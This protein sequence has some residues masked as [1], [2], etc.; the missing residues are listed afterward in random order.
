[1]A[2]RRRINAQGA[3]TEHAFQQRVIGLLRVHGFVHIFHAPAGGHRGRAD[4]EQIPEGR[5]FPDLLAIH[6]LMP[7]ILVVELKATEALAQPGRLRPG[8]AE[9]LAAFQRVGRT[10]GNAYTY[11]RDYGAGGGVDGEP[12]VEAYLW[13]PADWHGQPGD[14]HDVIRAGR[15]R[16]HDLDPPEIV[17]NAW[18]DHDAA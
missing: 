15:P 14:L 6:G 5:G 8:Q 9:W 7:R 10:V 3:E 13:T 11:A 16:R 4:R 1:M 18:E 2:A 12:C 17:P